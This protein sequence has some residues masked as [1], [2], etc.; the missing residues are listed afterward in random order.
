MKMKVVLAVICF[1]VVMFAIVF[2]SWGWRWF[3]A[4]IKGQIGKRENVQSA[5]YRQYSYD[6]FFDLYADV[7]AIQNQI[8]NQK[9]IID[10]SESKKERRRYRQNISGLMSQRDRLI[11]EYNA[12]ARKEGTRGQFKAD[13]LP[14]K[15]T[16]ENI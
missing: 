16:K 8:E 4:P 15:L 1:I 10:N 13:K 5:E 7:K 11:Q 2:A 14:T 9:M 3:S 6:H 12:D